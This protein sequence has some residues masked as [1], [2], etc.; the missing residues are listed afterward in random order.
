VL[1]SRGMSHSNQVREFV[2][3]DRGIDVLDVYVGPEGVLTGTSRVVQEAKEKAAALARRQ[4]IER[5]ERELERRRAAL[6]AQIAKLRAD[7]E[8]EQDE[9]RRL[10]NEGQQREATLE[11]DEKVVARRRRA[12]LTAVGAGAPARPPAP[13]PRRPRGNGNS[14]PQARS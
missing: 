3:T 1:K 9:L 10:V 4:D 2:L 5:R 8:G 14:R 11:A 7:F 13:G 6:E 12:D